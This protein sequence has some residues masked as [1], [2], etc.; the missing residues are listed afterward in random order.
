MSGVVDNPFG[1]FGIFPVAQW[2]AAYLGD[3]AIAVACDFATRLRRAAKRRAVASGVIDH[4][5]DVGFAHRRHRQP[6]CGI[7]RVLPHNLISLS[8]P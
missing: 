4:R 7:I 6:A 8:N 1:V 5:V 2:F 3:F